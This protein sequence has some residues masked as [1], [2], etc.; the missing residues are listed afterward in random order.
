MTDTLLLIADVLLAGIFVVLAIQLWRDHYVGR[1][2]E[3]WVNWRAD[4]HARKER[5]N[6][7]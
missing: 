3:R 7:R 5:D 2:Q 1:I 6:G 4:R